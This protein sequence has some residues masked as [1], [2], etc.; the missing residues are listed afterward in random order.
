ML[1]G[2]GET[3]QTGSLLGN[4]LKRAEFTATGVGIRL[5]MCYF[6]CKFVLNRM[7]ILSIQGLELLIIA[8]KVGPGKDPLSP[9]LCRHD[10][11]L[12]ASWTPGAERTCPL[13]D[14]NAEGSWVVPPWGAPSPHRGSCQHAMGVGVL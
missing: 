7:D 11:L 10:L 13:T 6:L 12:I 5:V 3:N 9:L 8:I 1:E 4:G 2:S 14:A